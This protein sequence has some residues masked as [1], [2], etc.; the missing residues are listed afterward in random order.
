MQVEKKKRGAPLLYGYCQ[1]GGRIVEDA[2][3]QA[4]LKEI[5]RLKKEGLR[6]ADIAAR[7]NEAGFRTRVGGMWAGAD[8]RSKWHRDESS[9]EEL[10]ER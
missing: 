4:I 8:V 5:F 6:S 9:V 10:L 2:T 3:E 1:R 7:L